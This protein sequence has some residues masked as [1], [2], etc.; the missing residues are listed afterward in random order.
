MERKARIQST[1][2]D[3]SLTHKP[4]SR[5]MCVIK[6]A[7][8][9]NEVDRM[10]ML[11]TCNM[12]KIKR[13]EYGQEIDVTIRPESLRSA[14]ENGSF[15]RSINKTVLSMHKKYAHNEWRKRNKRIACRENN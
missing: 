7:H 8:M 10:F 9:R 13:L 3:V 4:L 6:T 5:T 11:T 1:V 2:S 15:G 12:A 14:S